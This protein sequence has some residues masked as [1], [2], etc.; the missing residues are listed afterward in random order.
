M[1]VAIASLLVEVAPP[2][3]VRRAARAARAIARFA[4]G[5]GRR[6][7]CRKGVARVV[8]A[9]EAALWE[10]GAVIDGEG[11]VVADLSRQDNLSGT[12]NV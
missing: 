3:Q 7:W 9:P 1:R 8:G 5:R 4:E 10:H 6:S 12:K 2:D 11:A